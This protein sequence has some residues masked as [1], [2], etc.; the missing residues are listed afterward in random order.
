MKTF[1]KKIMISIIAVAFA[2]IALG[3][4]TFA[5]FAMNT[6]VTATGMEVSVKSNNTYLMIGKEN[7]AANIQDNDETSTVAITFQNTEVLPSA[8]ALS[9]AE[10]AYLPVQT[11]YGNG[12]QIPEGKQIGDVKVAGLKDDNQTAITVAGAQVTDKDSVALVTN[13]YTAIAATVDAPDMKAG[14]ARQLSSFTGYVLIDTVYLTVAEGANDA[15]NLK[16]TPTITQKSGGT[17]VSA[18]KVIVATVDKMVVLDNSDN[19]TAIDLFDA[20][21]NTAIVDDDVLEVKIYVYY[22]GNADPVFTN[23]RVNLKGADIELAFTVDP[24]ED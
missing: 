23:N 24:I 21:H 10:A 11:Y 4:S 2:F 6:Q 1:T 5:W 14:S 20:S 3:T 19:N 13:W 18:I 12:D 22:D 8:P 17:D 16:V 9:A 7:T 15:H